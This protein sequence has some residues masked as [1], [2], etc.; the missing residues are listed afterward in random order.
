MDESFADSFAKWYETFPAYQEGLVYLILI[1]SLLAL[2]HKLPK[3][4]HAIDKAL[5]WFE[6][7]SLY[8]MVIVG[9]V[10]LLV[11]VILRYGFHYALAWSEEL[12]REIII[13]S[14]FIGCSAAIKNRSMITIDAL[15]QI[16]PRLRTPLG[17]F[18][19]FSVLV[20]SVMIAR[21]GVEM[22]YMQA[23]THQA[24]IILEIP[25]VAVYVILPVMGFL[26]W[27]RTT[28]AI[29]KDYNEGKAAKAG[30]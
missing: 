14:T 10:S 28:Q 30:A 1:V 8:L 5:S 22:A 20:F 11:N 12:I 17:Y 23:S 6:G 13:Y 21:L 19:H 2:F 9:L 24:T 29:I 16:V 3:L 18:S 25:L 7:W 15:V 4:N 27:I 26:M